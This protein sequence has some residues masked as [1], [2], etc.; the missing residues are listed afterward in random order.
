MCKKLTKIFNELGIE[1]MAKIPKLHELKGDFI[2][3][4][5]RTVQRANHKNS[6]G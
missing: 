1:D 6:V 2:N 5:M 3:P 4:D